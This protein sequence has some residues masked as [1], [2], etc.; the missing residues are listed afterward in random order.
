LNISFRAN[1]RSFAHFALYSKEEAQDKKYFGVKKNSFLACHPQG[2]DR[3]EKIFCADFY[4][5]NPRG[6]SPAGSRV[7]HPLAHPKQRN[8]FE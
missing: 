4:Q 7:H 3:R 6:L 1:L 2:F 5:G 8:P